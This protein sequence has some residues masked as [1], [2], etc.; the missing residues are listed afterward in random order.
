MSEANAADE[1]QII[2]Y[3]N[4][5][6]AVQW[7]PDVCQHSGVCVRTLPRVYNPQARP[8]ITPEN[9]TTDELKAQI[10]LC[11]SGALTYRDLTDAEKPATA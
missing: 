2:E 5:E 4:G 10:D 3:P 6:I 8:W 7:R 9:A 1:T 11:P